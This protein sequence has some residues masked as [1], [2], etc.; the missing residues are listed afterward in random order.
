MIHL[1]RMSDIDD[2][3]LVATSLI[4]YPDRNEDKFNFNSPSNFFYE[5]PK[6]IVEQLR[7][8]NSSF[9]LQILSVCIPFDLESGQE[10]VSEVYID[11]NNLSFSKYLNNTTGTSTLCVPFPDSGRGDVGSFWHEFTRPISIPVSGPT[12][13]SSL[14]FILKSQKGEVLRF[15]EN[16]R[17]TVINMSISKMDTEDFFYVT[18]NHKTSENIY[19]K[20]NTPSAFFVDFNQPF[21]LE[22]KWKMGLHSILTSPGI[23]IGAQF[24]MTM[25]FMGN[26]RETY[27]IKNTN[28]S[29]HE[30]FD[31]IQNKL[32]PHGVLL[33][34]RGGILVFEPSGDVNLKSV[35]LNEAILSLLTGK[36]VWYSP[37]TFQVGK[38]S[39][40]FRMLRLGKA[41]PMQY[42]PLKKLDHAVVYC[43][44]AKDSVID[45]TMKP[46]VELVST[47]SIGVL[48]PKGVLYEVASQH[49]QS[50]RRNKF[51][52]MYVWM[53]RLGGGDFFIDT[54]NESDTISFT[55]VFMRT[56]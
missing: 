5:I 35:T 23:Q 37:K 43:D 48:E 25:E 8:S 24:E 51:K 11:F 29:W 40:D 30:V 16:S 52:S 31:K 6:N 42:E 27:S 1:P 34:N 18:V 7:E 17:P 46:F 10:D 21:E 47:E 3:R 2:V 49:F 28:Q 44:I 15:K 20:I 55:F 32:I 19:S 13:V 12:V 39:N 33:A 45:N 26:V 54:Q 56:D 50:V 22:G 38:L 53:E 36:Q 9:E 41:P 14:H 4:A